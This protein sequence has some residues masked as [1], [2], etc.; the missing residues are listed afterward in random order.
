MENMH[1]IL[2]RLFRI[3]RIP[4]RYIDSNSSFAFFTRGYE[5]LNDPIFCDDELLKSMTAC[6][7]TDDIPMIQYE[8]TIAYGIYKNSYDDIIIIGPI[9]LEQLTQA[10]L[11]E[12]AVKHKIS[13]NG[14]YI[15]QRTISYLASTLILIYHYFTGKCID[16][17]E[18]IQ[19][20]KN[21]KKVS[22]EMD[23]E[24]RDYVLENVEEENIRLSYSDEL[25]FL[26]QIQN[27]DI[28]G[29][30]KIAHAY[31]A[32]DLVGRLAKKPQKK[33]EYMI[34]ASITLVVRAAI[35]GGLD[36]MTSYSVGDVYF[37]K[38][39]ECKNINEIFSIQKPMLIDFA[40]RV[41]Q[42]KDEHSQSSHIEKCKYY[43]ANH[44][45]VPF[46]L[47]DIADYISI[48]K[49]YL[50]RQFTKT[51]GIGIS[52]YTQQKRI[53]AASNML[54]Y[55]NESISTI[56]SYLCFPSQSH[57]GKVFK[58]FMGVT[59]QKYRNKEKLIDVR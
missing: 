11:S 3:A 25:M 59:P 10:N 27:G 37:Q 29:A 43:I 56:S 6:I 19:N 45:N 47:D 28:E 51:E 55:S 41:R 18:I 1:F 39:S 17:Y 2:E 53:E 21:D 57:F 33:Y 31:G 50:S 35:A 22:E 26:E 42:V 52:K 58:E 24:V 16:E 20:E 32:E 30:Y 44:L 46:T 23:K 49:S 15:K 34:A 5:R 8:G 14:F 12:Y 4:I 7:S 48:N 13:E 36:P 9:S 40:K 38:L 54:K